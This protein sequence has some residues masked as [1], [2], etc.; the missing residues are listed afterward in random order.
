[1]MVVGCGL[2]ALIATAGL[3]TGEVYL[4]S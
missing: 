1:V 3:A 2:V 4:S